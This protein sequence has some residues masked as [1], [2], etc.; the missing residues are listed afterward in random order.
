MSRGTADPERKLLLSLD[1]GGVRGLSSIIILQ[2]I[3]RAVN[4][5]RSSDDQ[6]EPW[7]LF[8]MIGGTSTGGL[9]AVMLG[10]LRMSLDECEKTY[11]TFS[12]KIFQP[13]RKRFAFGSKASDFLQANGRFDS[14]ALEA[15]IKECIRSKDLDPDTALL[16]EEDSECNEPTH[17]R[18][19]LYDECRIWE[20]CRATSAA[21]TFFDPITFG[22]HDQTFVDG[23]ILYNNPI[24]LVHREAQNIWP[25]RKYLLLSIG[26]GS[27]PGKAFKGNVKHLIDSMKS[28]LTQTER[29]ANDF[30]Q[31]HQ[32]TNIGLEEH[33]ERGAMADA[34]QTYLD[35]GEVAQKLDKSILIE[36][37][38]QARSENVAIAGG[39]FS[40]QDRLQQTPLYLIADIL[41]QLLVSQ[42]RGKPLSED[43]IELYESHIRKRT[44]PNFTEYKAVIQ[45]ELR[46]YEKVFIILDAL[47]EFAGDEGTLARF[48]TEVNSLGPNVKLML[49]SRPHIDI[50]A[51]IINALQLEIHANDTD[52]RYYLEGRVPQIPRLTRLID[53]RHDLRNM[54]IDTIAKRCKGMYLDLVANQ[55]SR[56]GVRKALK[57]LPTGLERMFAATIKMIE[58]RENNT[59]LLAERVL[60]WACYALR[61]LALKKLQRA[62]AVSPGKYIDEDDVT[63]GDIILSVCGGLITLEAESG[64]IRFVHNTAQEFFLL[65]SKS[66]STEI[67]IF[68][69]STSPSYLCLPEF[70]RGDC[71]G[72]DECEARLVKYPFYLYASANWGNHA[73][74][75]P[76]SALFD[77]IFK[78][79]EDRP[80]E[81]GSSVQAMYIPQHRRSG[82]SRLYPNRFTTLWLATTFGLHEIL[83]KLFKR[84]T[85]PKIH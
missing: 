74:G 22:H 17:D 10:R 40:Y 13:K 71:L 27:V 79:L 60:S 54:I 19:L 63:D 16:K 72:D 6:L 15:A 30:Y 24:Q 65:L 23:G 56:T 5:D 8:D 20:A 47:D 45:S 76:E 53:G 14:K 80:L 33:K 39:F 34:T 70:S 75:E 61:P 66:R 21:T 4:A 82:F 32:Y 37:L 57:Q 42:D 31:G 7:Q 73:R 58:S 3:M 12:E 9:I 84:Q 48:L 41:K 18:A 85:P 26:T 25:G 1:G 68:L 59:R 78:F 50:A 83:E 51:V 55:N 36:Y 28:I 49:T 46:S 35:D 11:L 52:I 67:Q 38:H 44:T 77:T 81:L 62:L 2:H 43:V 29:T 64:L 69:A